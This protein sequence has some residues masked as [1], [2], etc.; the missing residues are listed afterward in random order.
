MGSV[1]A[2]A[3]VSSIQ[4]PLHLAPVTTE[5]KVTL[6]VCPWEEQELPQK[7]EKAKLTESTSASWEP[8]TEPNKKGSTSSIPC[9][10][11][12]SHE[13]PGDRSPSGSLRSYSE[14][15]PSVHCDKSSS[16]SVNQG[17]TEVSRKSPTI[18]LQD[19]LTLQQL[20][21][22]EGFT[23]PQRPVS[24][25]SNVKISLESSFEGDKPM[26]RE[27]SASISVPCTALISQQSHLDY[28]VRSGHLPGQYGLQ[29][30]KDKGSGSVSLAHSSSHST[31]SSSG[32]G[33]LSSSFIHVDSS[34]DK[35]GP[36]SVPCTPIVKRTETPR[37]V[38]VSS[39]TQ[40]D[41]IIHH[42]TNQQTQYPA[43]DSIR[44]SSKH[45]YRHSKQ[46]STGSQ[47]TTDYLKS[48]QPQQAK[49]QLSSRQHQMQVQIF[50][51][52]QP[53][54][55]L[56][57]Y[58]KSK[59]QA[60][61][62]QA[63]SSGYS[64]GQQTSDQLTRQYYITRESHDQPFYNPPHSQALQQPEE[65]SNQKHSIEKDIQLQE[66][67]QQH[68]ERKQ[69][70][71]RIREEQAQYEIQQR[72]L[73][74]HRQEQDLQHQREMLQYEKQMQEFQEKQQRYQEKR[75]QELSSIQQSKPL[76]C[77]QRDDRIHAPFL[78]SEPEGAT[79]LSPTST[80]GK[81]LAE[82]HDSPPFT[83]SSQ[84]CQQL[85]ISS[86][87]QHPQIS[88]SQ[89]QHHKTCST[90][91]GSF[92][93][94]QQQSPSSCAQTLAVSQ[95][96]SRQVHSTTQMQR[97]NPVQPTSSG[98]EQQELAT[99]EANDRSTSPKMQ[100]QTPKVWDDPGDICP[101]EDE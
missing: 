96:T 34:L 73:E 41:P 44:H 42:K 26:H 32:D 76:Q 98:A 92:Q 84:I 17:D 65:D 24:D 101:W 77:S 12:S 1:C 33:M 3:L 27:L 85:Q 61:K 36:A 23:K 74:Q 21:P 64:D 4:A 39:Q 90:S 100:E 89:Q 51:K 83:K 11:T 80:Y 59:P 30:S 47:Y 63:G 7:K 25:L 66:Q 54:S 31:I 22:S 60:T 56:Q 91:K 72:L 55:T 52:P 40:T 35:G 78:V 18:S 16:M 2:P 38:S 48:Y 58:T 9:I 46:T 28:T 45:S 62:H 8:Q 68:K 87:H 67:Y 37:G 5:S 50:H 57:E 53:V 29:G 13:T 19:T 75:V 79:A 70:E 88:S 94:P 14:R 43:R 95:V 49:T 99:G 81:L 10:A 15:R 20:A 97:Q 6:N 71:M 69:Q 82:G 86:A 93:S